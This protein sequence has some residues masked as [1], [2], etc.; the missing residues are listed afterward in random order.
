MPKRRAHDVNLS[1]MICGKARHELMKRDYIT[2][3]AH[4]TRLAIMP[5]DGL[6]LANC[7]G[8][9]STLTVPLEWETAHY[10]QLRAQA[11]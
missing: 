1:E 2:F 3:M 11:G 10:E 7:R 9:G 5:D 4:T 6:L 8:C